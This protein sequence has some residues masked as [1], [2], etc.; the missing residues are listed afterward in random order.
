MP[1]RD[2]HP[3]RETLPDAGESSAAILG[4][5]VP[6]QQVGCSNFRLP[7]RYRGADGSETELETSVTGTVSLEA[8]R[9]AINMGRIVRLFYERRSEAVSHAMIARVLAAYKRG[10]GAKEARL[11]LEASHPI[12][13]RSLRSGLTGWQ[14]Y[15]MVLEAGIDGRGRLSRV[16]EFDFVYSSTCP[17]SAALAEHSRRIR[18]IPAAPHSQRSKARIRVLLAPGRSLSADD[19]RKLCSAALSTETQSMVKREDEQAFA[20]LNGAH[21]KFVEDAARLLYREFDGDRRIRDFQIACA[22]LESLHSHDAVSVICKG[23]KG[24]FVA[25]FQDFRSLVC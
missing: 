7:L 20:E 9:K 1:K 4:A 6:L 12:A 3:R 22:H 23:V 24:G 15:R 19:L 10:I 5:D 17:S 25:D 18:G 14:Y 21:L 2:T 11:R 13:Q 8:G 16:I